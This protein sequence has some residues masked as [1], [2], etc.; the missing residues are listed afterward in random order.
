MLSNIDLYCFNFILGLRRSWNLGEN[1]PSSRQSQFEEKIGRNP[2]TT[3]SMDC[4]IDGLFGLY[5][6]G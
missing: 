2:T 5:H 1:V 3:P 6:F 4:R